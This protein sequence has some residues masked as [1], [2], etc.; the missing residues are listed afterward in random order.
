MPARPPT[1][2][3]SRRRA[4][5]PRRPA[6]RRAARVVPRGRAGAGRIRWDRMGRVALL[7]VLFGIVVLY[8]G[9]RA[10]TSS[11]QREAGQRRARARAPQAEHQRLLAR[12]ADLRRP[13]ALER[14]ARRLG[15]VKP[16]E[17]PYVVEHLPSGP[18]AERR[19]ADP[20]DGR[21]GRRASLAGVAF[22]TAIHQWREGDRRLRDAPDRASARP[23]SASP[24]AS[25][26]SCAAAWACPSRPT[27]SSSSTTARA[28]RW[29]TDL[30]YAVAPGAP[31][32]WDA[33]TVA[34]A[35]FARYLREALDFAGG[36]RVEAL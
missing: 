31:W 21:G 27:S 26:T 22:E 13:A 16:G 12:R 35:A 28:P 30:A 3:P 32:A 2:V 23:S 25:T 1:P 36:R 14:E 29:A 5:S 9:P 11:T 15:M 6:P 17:R 8:A 4:P 34:D 20:R 7:V 24:G 33:R 18:C 19:P 10:P